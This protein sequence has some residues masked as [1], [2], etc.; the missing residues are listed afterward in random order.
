MRGARYGYDLAR[1]CGGGCLC[2]A[3]W[4]GWCCTGVLGRVRARQWVIRVVG[5]AWMMAKGGMWR[6]ACKDVTMKGVVAVRG[7]RWEMPDWFSALTCCFLLLLHLFY[8]E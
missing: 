2:F 3:G 5:V 6:T 4:L 7:A 1:H 8:L